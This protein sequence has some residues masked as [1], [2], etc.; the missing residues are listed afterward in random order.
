MRLSLQEVNLSLLDEKAEEL[1][2]DEEG[3]L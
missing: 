1:E 3:E 2:E